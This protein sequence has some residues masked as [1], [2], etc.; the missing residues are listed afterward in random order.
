MPHTF[1]HKLT[2]SAA[3]IGVRGNFNIQ[4]HVGT[5]EAQRDAEGPPPSLSPQGVAVSPLPGACASQSSGHGG[6]AV[7]GRWEAAAG[8][9]L[10]S[11]RGQASAWWQPWRG[12][13]PLLSLS[14]QLPTARPAWRRPPASLTAHLRW[15][16]EGPRPRPAQPHLRWS[17]KMGVRLRGSQTGPGGPLQG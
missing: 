9:L 15:Q 3:G 1:T 6:G 4:G 14:F 2:L 10:S 17:A 13:L 8:P 12:L 11:W 7:A 16:G 5:S